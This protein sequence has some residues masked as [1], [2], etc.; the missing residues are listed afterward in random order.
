ML[1]LSHTHTHTHIHT[2]SVYV[3]DVHRFL[4]NRNYLKN[5]GGYMK[6]TKLA[7]PKHARGC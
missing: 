5:L 2:Q 3:T 4:E 1:F 7:E 6:Y